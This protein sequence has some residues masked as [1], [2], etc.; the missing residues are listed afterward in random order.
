MMI[1]DVD[2]NMLILSI[3]VAHVTLL[4]YKVLKLPPP[5]EING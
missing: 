5:P 1:M 3:I 4:V 2:I